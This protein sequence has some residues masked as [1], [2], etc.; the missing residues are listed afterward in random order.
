[1]TT[2][3]SFIGV[4]I[5]NREKLLEMIEKC[6]R[7]LISHATANSINVHSQEA[8]F[9]HSCSSNLKKK[10]C[11]RLSIANGMELDKIPEELMKTTDLEQQLFARMLI[12]TKIVQLPN[13]TGKRMKGLTG[14]MINVPLEQ[15]DI[16]NSIKALP[17]CVDDAA[18]VPLQLKKKKE[19]KSAYAEAFVRPEVC[20]QAVEKLK[21]LGNPYYDDVEIDHKFMEKGE[22]EQPKDKNEISDNDDEL[23]DVEILN[24]VKTFQADRD[25]NTCLVRE[26][27]EAIVV[28]NKS[29]KTIQKKKGKNVIS[30][31]PGENKVILKSIVRYMEDVNRLYFQIF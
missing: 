8:I 29:K 26:D 15:S 13:R 14:K 23:E 18:V 30:I 21:E 27:L 24:S 7:K 2:Y 6:G 31:Q 25:E 3:T 19:F 5:L 9:C 22:K 1:M 20:I 12:F 28:E 4:K 16:S 17:R 11:P 10:K